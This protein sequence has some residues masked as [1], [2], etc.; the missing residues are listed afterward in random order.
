MRGTAPCVLS[1]IAICLVAT[2]LVHACS[3]PVK[4]AKHKSVH[5]L[6]R[7][8]LAQPTARAGRKGEQLGD[9]DRWRLVCNRPALDD[10]PERSAPLAVAMQPTRIQDT[11]SDGVTRCLH[12]PVT[13]HLQRSQGLACAISRDTCASL[14]L[15]APW[16][17]QVKS[18]AA[19]DCER[20]TTRWRTRRSPVLQGLRRQAEPGVAQQVL[21]LHQPQLAPARHLP[22]APSPYH[23]VANRLRHAELSSCCLCDCVSV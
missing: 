9:A 5:G 22:A 2:S 11:H 12:R 6:R 20:R 23:G 16:P 7:Q 21:V 17:L 4:L 3:E 1:N 19:P 14:C 8:L 15:V 13:A 18:Q 10:A